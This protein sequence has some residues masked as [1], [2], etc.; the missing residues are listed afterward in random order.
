M[1]KCRDAEKRPLKKTRL[2]SYFLS[3]A[4]GALAGTP[5]SV[6]LSATNIPPISI[7]S[8]A[9]VEILVPRRIGI[10]RSCKL[11]RCKQLVFRGEG[12]LATDVLLDFANPARLPR[13]R[14]PYRRLCPGRSG[15]SVPKLPA[16]P[17]KKAKC[18]ADVVASARHVLSSLL[19]VVSVVM[20]A[21]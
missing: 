13:P 19:Y 15:R 5:S 8:N 10:D 18:C 12:H 21:C 4:S 2:F 9:Q 20:G 14:T 1:Q 7:R 3:C 17:V 11:T 6:A 16:N